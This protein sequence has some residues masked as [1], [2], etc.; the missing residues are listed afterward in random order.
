MTEQRKIKEAVKSLIIDGNVCTRCLTT[1]KYVCG[2][3]W[4]PHCHEKK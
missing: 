1:K 2:V 4:C 3:E